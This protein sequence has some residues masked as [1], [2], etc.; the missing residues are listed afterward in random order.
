MY[1]HLF[2]ALYSSY[3]HGDASVIH[4]IGAGGNGAA[5]LMRLYK[6]HTTL[7]ALGRPGLSVLVYDDDTVSQSNLGRQPFYPSDVGKNKA[8][9]LVNRLKLVDQS[10]SKWLAVPERFTNDTRMMPA[11]AVITCVD[12]KA[13]RRAVH[14]RAFVK[15]S[16]QYW[17]DMGNESN[18]G[19]IVL[20]ECKGHGRKL[21]LPV[22]T[23]LYPEILDDTIAESNRPSCST[24]EALEKQD[25]FINETVVSHAAGLLWQGLHH[26]IVT[27]PVIYVDTQAHRV[28]PVAIDS[29]FY[30]RCGH[31][32]G[33]N[34]NESIAVLSDGH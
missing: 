3:R 16:C 2:N 5:M 21:R 4:L 28:T 27:H 13:S 31:R 17:L 23:E 11:L 7:I 20:G 22:V 10:T 30:K 25:L 34:K 19:Q 18:T 1:S 32:T 29:D 26:R 14:H 9:V 15:Q 24:H 33:R 8:V 12:N 6:M